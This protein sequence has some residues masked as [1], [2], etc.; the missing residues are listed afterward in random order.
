M[1]NWIFISNPNR[2]RMD[3]WLRVNQLIGCN[4]KQI[5]GYEEFWS[6]AMD[7]AATGTHHRNI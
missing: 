7:D 1:T 3:D 2:F 6:K 4:R 5:L